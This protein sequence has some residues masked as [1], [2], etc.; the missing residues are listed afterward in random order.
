V[1]FYARMRVPLLRVDII[2]IA[3]FLIIIRFI[4]YLRVIP[5]WGPMLLAVVD[6]LRDAT[7][8]LYLAVMLGLQIACAFAFHVAFGAE[9]NHFSSITRAFITVFRMV[10][11]PSPPACVRARFATF[12]TQP[13]HALLSSTLVASVYLHCVSQVFAPTRLAGLGCCYVM[14]RCCV[15]HLCLC[16]G[17]IM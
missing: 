6:T 16:T 15:L 3:L 8:L 9:N 10:C 13:T 7:V 5:G 4:K 2:A 14:R 1:C 17:A 12:W 11:P